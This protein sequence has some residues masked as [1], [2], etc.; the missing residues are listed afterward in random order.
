MRGGD[1]DVAE[2][3]LKALLVRPMHHRVLCSSLVL[4]CCLC[5]WDG[6]S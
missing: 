6:E 5:V 1:V 4:G 3:K 2:V